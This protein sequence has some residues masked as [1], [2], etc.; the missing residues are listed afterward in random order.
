METSLDRQRR[1]FLQL[2]SRGRSFSSINLFVG[3]PSV[4]TIS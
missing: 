1:P 2:L 3:I 4:P